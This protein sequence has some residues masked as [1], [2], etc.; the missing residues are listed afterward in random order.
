MADYI[1][2]VV[3]M[4]W[5]TGNERCGCP[6]R[7]IRPE[8]LTSGVK[9]DFVNSPAHYNKGGVE[10]I[11]AI[12][13]A[14][15]DF[16]SYCQGNAIKYLYRHAYKGNP[17]QDLEKAIWYINKLKEQYET[18]RISKQGSSQPSRGTGSSNGERTGTGA[19]NGELPQTD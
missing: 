4:V 14:V 12:E 5:I 9:S 13:A 7:I 11:D 1:Q 3:C 15:E 8:G 16:P 19:R 2:C 17:V 10:C 6:D 18:K